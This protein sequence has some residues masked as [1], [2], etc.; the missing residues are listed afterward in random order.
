MCRLITFIT[1]P[2]MEKHLSWK[3]LKCVDC[4]DRWKGKL[5][6]NHHTSNFLHR[7]KFEGYYEII[8]SNY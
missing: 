7:L 2:I 8:F 5:E 3:V 4:G 6:K 1:I